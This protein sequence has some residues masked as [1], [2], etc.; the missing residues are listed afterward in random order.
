MSLQNL[1]RQT[2]LNI[3]TAMFLFVYLYFVIS[4]NMTITTTKL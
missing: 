4:S 2:F 3:T 1:T